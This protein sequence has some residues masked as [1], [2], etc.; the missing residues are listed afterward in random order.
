MPGMSSAAAIQGRMRRWRMA[1]AVDEAAAATLARAL[2]AHPLIGRLLLRRG[3][4]D[5][6][7]ARRFFQPKLT[8]LHDPRALPGCAAAA[9]RI[10]DA[11]RA[12][13][14][15]V[16]YGDYD[17][18]GVTATAILHHMLTTC[19]PDAEVRRYIP[20]RLDEG[21]GLNAEALD[22]LIDDG[23]GLIV[24]VD[25]GI[26]A[27]EPAKVARRRGVDLIVT[28]H[29]QFAEAL[30]DAH[31]LVHPRLAEH[32]ACDAGEPGYPFGELCGAGVAYKLAWQIARQ[33][34]G[35]E[36][37]S[38]DLRH[39]LVDLLPLAALGT[40]ADVVPL[41][42][43][44]RII[45]K[46]G[47]GQI[48]RTRFEGL[49]ALIAAS[50]LDS[51]KIDAYHVGF[52]LGPRLNACGRMGHA[53]DACTLLTT[54]AGEEAA[55]IAEQLNGENKQRQA[56]E[57]AIFQQAVAMI[58][59]AGFDAEDCRAIV[60]GHEQ[61]HP[62]VVGIVCSRLVE[63]FG[64]PVVLLNTADGEATGSARSIDGFDIHAAF[65]AC[66]GHLTTYG[67]HAMAAGLRLAT[68][69]VEAFRDDL[70]AVANAALGVE[71]LTPVLDL[72]ADLDL[73]ELTPNLVE[74]IDR[75][76]PF[77]RA[78]PRPAL[79]VRAAQLANPPR[80]VGS[81]GK[82]LTLMVRQGRAT[83]RGIAF[84]RGEFARRL[85]QGQTLDLAVRPKLNRF[86]GRTSVELEVVDLD[87]GGGKPIVTP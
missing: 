49:N 22:A 8:D 5:A 32:P 38:E 66:A 80:T 73:D 83:V 50:K 16:I 45:A 74:Q 76:A 39:L 2:H 23:A 64:R 59:E 58:E 21:Y 17:V 19:R 62:G 69:R 52:V 30:P 15:I 25:C 37:V 60:L 71:D 18:D 31:T 20:H 9:T 44:N 1:P 61:W 75:L 41:V 34:C 78:N 67:G 54:A 72:E 46:F 56:T 53:R 55:V 36:K 14:P 7:P 29:H 27:V 26:T 70:V 65:T 24:S 3:I 6:E 42:D 4:D 84:N 12:G 43:E 82:H 85:W 77:G 33:W 63:R 11:L 86:N 40:I 57:R 68:E 10:V 79:R 13:E 87:A 47:L 35:S 28:D 51:E 48:K 81:G